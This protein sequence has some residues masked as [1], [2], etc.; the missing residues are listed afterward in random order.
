MKEKKPFVANKN[1]FYVFI[2]L[3]LCLLSVIL[4]L[5]TGV[6]ARVLST[7]FTFV[8]GSLSYFLYIAVNVLGLRLIF[9]KKGIKIKFSSYLLASLILFISLSMFFT[10]FAVTVGRGGFTLGMVTSQ[11]AQTINFFE[12]Y[13][14]VFDQVEGGYLWTSS[15]ML[16]NEIVEV[17]NFREAW[18]KVKSNHGAAGIDKM[19][20]DFRANETSSMLVSRT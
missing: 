1:H 9:A 6:V 11:E 14:G 7:P 8:F 18:M 12:A 15:L 16:I 4:V 17:R 20:T 19:P 5:N 3:F 10:H 2:G 13:V